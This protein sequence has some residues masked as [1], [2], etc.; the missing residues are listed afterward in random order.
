MKFNKSMKRLR[1]VDGYLGSAVLNYAGET[2]FVDQKK[3]NIDIAYSAAVFNDALR[4]VSNSSSDIGLS[5][6]SFL[7]T[8]TFDGHVFLINSTGDFYD[9]ELSKL[10]IFAI[11]RD[12]GNIGLAKM[13]IDK[14]SKRLSEKLASL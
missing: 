3:T 13:I 2:L 5:D 11:F 12:D 6:C 7:E 10:N 8:K 4:T 14:T 1:S 9:D